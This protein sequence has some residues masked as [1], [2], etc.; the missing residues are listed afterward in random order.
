MY[1][2][3]GRNAVLGCAESA[4]S[5]EKLELGTEN[6]SQEFQFKKTLGTKPV[7]RE[8]CTGATWWTDRVITRQQFSKMI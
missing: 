2:S 8:T 1:R 4:K 7:F 6:A 3:R 5:L